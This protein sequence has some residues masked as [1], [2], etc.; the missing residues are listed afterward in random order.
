[1]NRQDCCSKILIVTQH[2]PSTIVLKVFPCGVNLICS[3]AR[4]ACLNIILQRRVSLL[5]GLFRKRAGAAI[6]D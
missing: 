5:E 1:M 6:V 3:D 2:F 4:I